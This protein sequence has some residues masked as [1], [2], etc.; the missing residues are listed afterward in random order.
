VGLGA[1]SQALGLGLGALLLDARGHAGLGDA[2]ARGDLLAHR[3]VGADVAHAGDDHLLDLGGREARVLAAVLGLPRAVAA[4]V[5]SVDLA[6]A[7]LACGRRHRLP[8]Q[9]AVEQAL[10]QVLGVAPA[11]GAAAAGLRVEGALH[12]LE[13]RRVDDGLVLAL[14]ALALEVHLAEVDRVAQEHVDVLLGPRAAADLAAGVGA[15]RLA[16]PAELVDAARDLGGGAEAQVELE[17]RPHL[18]GLVGHDHQ[19]HALAVAEVAERGPRAEP[20]PALAGGAHLVAGAVGDHLALELREADDDV[21]GVPP[22]RVAG[23]E[24]LGGRDEAVVLLLEAR[25]QLREVEERA[26]EAVDLVDDHDVDLARVDVGEQA[27]ERGALDVRA[28]EAAVVVAL[29]QRLPALAPHR[30]DVELRGLAL[31]VEGV[32]VGLE[33]LARRLAGVDGASDRPE[34]GGCR[35]EVPAHERPHEVASVRAGRWPGARR[36]QGNGDLPARRD[37]RADVP[38]PPRRGLDRLEHRRG[39]R[40]AQR[41]GLPAL[42]RHGLRLGPRGRVPAVAGASVGLPARRRPSRSRQPGDGDLEGAERPDSIAAALGIA[43]SGLQPPASSLSGFARAKTEE[44]EA[45]PARAGDLAC[46]G[47]E[48]RVV[49]ALVLEAVLEHADLVDDAVVLAVDHGAH[50]RQARVAGRLV[51]IGRGRQSR[52]RRGARAHALAFG[53]R[54]DAGTGVVAER[55]AGGDLLG[56]EEAAADEPLAVAGVRRLAV[57]VVVGVL[58]LAHRHG[59]EGLEPLAELLL[60]VRAGG[61]RLEGG[62]VHAV[63]HGGGSGA[64]PSRSAVGIHASFRGPSKRLLE[65]KTTT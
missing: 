53:E 49:A 62:S 42:P 33:P 21:E 20:L 63:L 35:L 14:V 52:R 36:L 12:L 61:A 50:R 8:A 27:L 37:V 15:G 48:A 38:A 3:P 7:P 56:A 41:S 30:P 34:T 13:E 2:H 57:G 26:A 64:E 28:G 58:Q 47:R 25:E 10:E 43:T 60:D 17:H 31:R 65:A 22:H 59:A 46:D 1:Q 32:E 9:A 29:G 55:H 44:Q 39:L 23:V 51:G 40:A 18:L 54:G 6:A 4:G 45:V 5:V 24:M 19:A 11:P 16:L